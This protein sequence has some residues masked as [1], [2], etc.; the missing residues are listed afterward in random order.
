MIGKECFLSLETGNLLGEHF[1]IFSKGILMESSLFLLFTD[2]QKRRSG[3][4][5]GARGIRKRQVAVHF[6]VD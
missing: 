3:G 2:G 1:F 4:V 6:T 5:L